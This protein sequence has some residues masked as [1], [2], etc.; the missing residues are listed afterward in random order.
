MNHVAIFASGAGSNALNLLASASTLENTK[1]SCV[2][3]D[4]KNSALLMSMKEKFPETPV[5]L[6]LPE[7]SLKGIIRRN[8][9]EER[10]IK[11]LKSYDVKWIL[12]AGYMR[13]LGKRIIHQFTGKN[14]I[15]RIIN[16]HPSL[17]PAYP[18]VDSYKRAFDDGVEVSGITIH[19]VDEGVD[20]GPVLM[21]EKFTRNENDKLS[22]FVQKGKD[23]EWKYYPEVLKKIDRSEI[24]A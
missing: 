21:Q 13:I 17:L 6:V 16:I 11:I 8:E 10:I 7:N 3:I 19:F 2:I 9:H 4:D 23:L 14:G 20:T 5:H 22:D 18:G 1:I 15:S 12:L 24:G